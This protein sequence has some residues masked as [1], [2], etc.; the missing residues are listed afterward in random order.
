MTGNI[1]I[2]VA[3]PD[4]FVREVIIPPQQRDRLEQIGQVTWNPHERQFTPEELRDALV[5]V[6]ALLTGWGTPRL[7]EFVLSKADRLRFVGHCAGSVGSI[8]SEALYDRQ[9]LITTAN[10]IMARQVAEF[11]VMLMLMG[12]RNVR[13]FTEPMY[14]DDE[15]YE[16]RAAFRSGVLCTPVKDI[17]VGVVGLG[18]IARWFIRFIRPMEPKILLYS[19]HTTPE[20]AVELGVELTDLDDLLARSDVINLL[21]GLTEETY[22]MINAERL[23]RMKDGALLI[24]VGRGALVDEDALVAELQTGRIS[25]ALDVFEV[26]PL[27]VDSPLRKLPNVILTPHY[28]GHGNEKEYG[29]FCIDEL[30]RFLRGEPLQGLVTREQ[31][32]NMTRADLVAKIKQEKLAARGKSHSA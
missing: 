31:W 15:H 30:E 4:D 7:D 25:A 13:Y 32:R 23:R 26:E 19:R 24:N 20:R 9:I 6:D 22:H 10:D 5:G 2:L 11:C 3:M 1:R 28:A 14:A 18:A 8:A 21:C 29:K 27:P 12:L 16:W 17:T